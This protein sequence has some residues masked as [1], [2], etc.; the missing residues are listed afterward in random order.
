MQ[1]PLPKNIAVDAGLVSM[2]DGGAAQRVLGEIRRL[3][4]VENAWELDSLGYTVIRPEQMG[5]QALAA[6]LQARILELSEEKTGVRPDVET[7]QTHQ[8]F[9][10]KLGRA[11]MMKDVLLQDPLFEQALMQPQVLALVAYLVGESGVLDT[12]NAT[13]KAPGPE[14]LSLHVDTGQ[15]APLPPYAQVANAT[16]VLS[17]YTVEN[18]AT[19][20]IPGSHKWGRTPLEHEQVDLSMAVP[21]EAK[22]GSVLIWHGNT[23][24]GAFPRTA[25]GLRV[26]LIMYFIRWYLR[27]QV[28]YA[29]KVTPEA[30]AR[31]GERFARI[32]GV[33]MKREYVTKIST[34]A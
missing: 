10:S 20:F 9:A 30:L 2:D 28:G 27:P 3:G 25:P 22:A 18:G 16:W 4:L 19:C 34:F 29:D 7:G 6:R 14:F 31:N 23:W 17:D 8:H 13:L 26:A 21:V 33:G 24:H 15:P 5:S 32:L 12:M 11:Q 1:K